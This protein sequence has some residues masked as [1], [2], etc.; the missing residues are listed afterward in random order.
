L[1][2]EDDA[3]YVVVVSCAE[4]VRPQLVRD[5][6]CSTREFDALLSRDC[7]LV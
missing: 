7:I 2:V 5:D 6:A 1:S 3:T 4:R